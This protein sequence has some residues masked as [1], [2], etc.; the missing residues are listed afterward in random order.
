[1]LELIE[2]LGMMYPT[3]KSK[4]KYR[5]GLYK[6]FCGNEFKVQIAMVKNSNTNSCGC[7]QKQR[8]KESNT[9][10]GKVSHIL[11]H[12]WYEMIQRCNN[13]N[14]KSYIDYGARG[15]DV[16][17]RWIKIENFIE[18]MYPSYK[19][20]LTLDRRNNNLGYSP[21]NCRWTNR[22][23]Q[24]RNKRKIQSN[25]KSGYKGVS[26]HKSSNKWISQ[27]SVN[28]KKIYLGIFNTPEEA[29]K[30]YDKYIKDNNLEHTRNFN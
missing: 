28:N 22:T 18:D 10:H 9:T 3:K 17:D 29:A 1:M 14:H 25:N 21:D 16:C 23:V 7:L 20:G 8:V 24:S 15:I 26:W 12:V 19:D 27:I 11:Y 5:F 2:D 6:C 4:R 13:R 30:A